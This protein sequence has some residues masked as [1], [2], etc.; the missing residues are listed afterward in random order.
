MKHLIKIAKHLSY[1]VEVDGNIEVIGVVNLLEAKP[2]Q[3]PLGILGPCFVQS[4][5]CPSGLCFT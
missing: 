3:S 4:L 2:H 1:C 5:L